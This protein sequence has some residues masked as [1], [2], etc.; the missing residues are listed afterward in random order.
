M[1]RI[2]GLRGI[3]VVAAACV[4]GGCLAHRDT[5]PVGP[6]PI[7][8]RPLDSAN[9]FAYETGVSDVSFDLVDSGR[10]YDVFRFDMA[11]SGDNG[12]PDRRLRATFYRAN[13][14][15]AR[16]LVVIMPIWGSYVYPPR[17]LAKTL[18]RKSKGALHVMVIDGEHF[19]FD[20]QRLAD[21]P[22]EQA[23]ERLS[24]AM[25]AR[26]RT[27]GI[28]MRRLLDWAGTQPDI[29]DAR[30]ALT[31][32]SMSAVIAALVIA[33]EPR[34]RS[35]VLVMGGA[36]PAEIFAACDGHPEDVRGAILERFGWDLDR[37]R[38]VWRRA[39]S[40]GDPAA[41]THRMPR[42]NILMIDAEH[43]QCMSAAARDDLWRAL[44]E[45]R[46]MTFRYGHK[47]SFLAMTPLGLNFM[48]RKIYEFLEDR[49]D[50]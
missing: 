28:D 2:I 21:A 32:F 6:T 27:V 36:R 35:A 44:G 19:L 11:S 43:D 13:G 15:G 1:I 16:P 7:P 18:R 29:D 31:G 40:D 41:V 5:G 9:P 24:L 38:S 23:F 12:H 25:A 30:I 45:P 26:V 49:L 3:G 10:R 50:D 22:T 4:L 39:F 42:E 34:Y 33:E 8:A 17:K 20:W 46:R 48:D 37:Y 14:D 47:K